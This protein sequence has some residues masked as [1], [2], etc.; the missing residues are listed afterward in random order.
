MLTSVCN[1]RSF[2]PKCGVYVLNCLFCLE[3]MFLLSKTCVFSHM[4]AQSDMK[5]RKRVSYIHGFLLKELIYL[6]NPAMMGGHPL[7]H[8]PSFIYIEYLPKITG[9]IYNKVPL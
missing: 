9:Q 6:N 4:L 7:V 8:V 1:I 2:L 3:T 5:T